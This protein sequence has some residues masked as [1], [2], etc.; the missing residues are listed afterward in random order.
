MSNNFDDDD[1]TF[2]VSSEELLV[3]TITGQYFTQPV[4]VD[5]HVFEYQPILKWYKEKGTHP[6]TRKR[7]D[8]TFK[9]CH[10]TLKML[11]IFF[12]K[13]PDRMKERYRPTY[14]RDDVIHFI[15]VGEYDKFLSYTSFNLAD[16]FLAQYEGKNLFDYLVKKEH[17]SRQK[18]LQH[19]VNEIVDLDSFDSNDN[20]LAHYMLKNMD[21]FDQNFVLKV[22][23]N[24]KLDFSKK[25]KDGY[26]PV[27]YYFT[28]KSDLDILKSIFDAVPDITNDLGILS[29]IFLSACSDSNYNILRFLVED[30]KVDTKV[31][32]EKGN[33][34]HRLCDKHYPNPDVL[35]LL[36]KHTPDELLHK[37]HDGMNPVAMIISKL[38]LYAD[39]DPWIKYRLQIL[40][41]LIIEKSCTVNVHSAKIYRQYDTVIVLFFRDL[42]Q[43]YHQQINEY[44]LSLTPKEI[45]SIKNEQTGDHL[46]HYIFRDCNADFV[47]TLL[48]TQ[49]YYGV[50]Y[51]VKNNEGNE[52]VYYAFPRQDFKL[53]RYLIN[54][55]FVNMPL[56]GRP[57]E[58]FDLIFKHSNA[59]NIRWA[60]VKRQPQTYTPL[61][62]F[63]KSAAGWRYHESVKFLKGNSNLS[64]EELITICFMLRYSRH[65]YDNSDKPRFTHDLKKEL[66]I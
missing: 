15:N 26:T 37:F 55:Y 22:I 36:A 64:E 6:E 5:S 4:L 2:E 50:F 43:R 27:A 21:I 63:K 62:M 66:E 56:E 42:Y 45:N 18:V 32:D 8:G 25:N 33:C 30:V 29:N 34:Y 60:I 16:M 61:S 48:E 49:K 31:S 1:L 10:R 9:P 35:L 38:S 51:N 54:S 65:K 58:R 19:I 12:K 52:P 39:S 47:Y 17:S 3:D 13:Y 57:T 46:I 41:F 7:M 59:D 53:H 14:T 44:I 20:N 24:K 11:D 23:S 28:V 40:D